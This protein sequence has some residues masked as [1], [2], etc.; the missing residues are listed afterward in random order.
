MN[1]FVF[2]DRDGVINKNR[3]DY[4]KSIDEFV[5]LTNAINGIKRLDD[6][7]N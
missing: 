5:F 7:Y 3:D 6:L 1:R 4:V 2:L